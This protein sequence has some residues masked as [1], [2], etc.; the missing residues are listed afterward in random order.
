MITKKPLKRFGQNFLKDKNILN[1]IT[2]I[3]DIKDKNIL[4]IGSGKGDL[5]DFFVKKANEVVIFEIDIFLLKELKQKYHG[6]SKIKI[7]EGD[8]LKCDLSEYKNYSIISN[9]P[10]YITTDIIF[11]IFEN[12][13]NF[14][15]VILMVQKEF[16]NRMCAKLNEKDYGKLSIST[17]IF[18][19][20]K[21]I[22]DVNASSFTPAPKVDSS[23]IHL[24]RRKESWK[25]DT[26]KILKFINLC[27][28][29]KRKMLKNNLKIMNICEKKFTLFCSQENISLD[30]RPENL[31]LE[32]YIKLFKF[33]H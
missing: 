2:N 32:Q 21:K 9:I 1:K 18:Y 17:A 29:M 7:I 11:K 24:K 15:D 26:N 8:F 10:Y 4:E 14:S 3:I 33:I 19:E 30:I 22:F 5:T 20:A 28:S 27:F 13:Q 25:L 31:S 23:V 16:A 6:Y 12:N